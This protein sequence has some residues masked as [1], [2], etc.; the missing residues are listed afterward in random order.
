MEAVGAI[1]NL[2]LNPLN[3]SSS[4]FNVDGFEPPT[5]HGAFIADRAEVDPGFFNA[6]GIELL[7]GR[8]FSEAD[9]PDTQPV[10]IIWEAM[11]RRCW[12]DG[13]ARRPA[14]AAA[15]P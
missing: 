10:A 5:D 8:N 13:D 12:S 1:S 4:D 6:A 15:R 11:A 2:H 3:T 9:R 14:G 7:H